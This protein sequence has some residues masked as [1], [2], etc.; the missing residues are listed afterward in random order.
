[1][2]YAIS[3]L[4]TVRIVFHLVEFSAGIDSSTNALFSTEGYTLGLDAVTMLLT[5]LLLALVHPGVVLKGPGS[6]F[7]SKKAK[8]AG[9]KKRR[10]MDKVEI[11]SYIV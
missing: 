5:L 11:V 9:R 1:M 7:P 4:I 10:D 3:V 8:K 6:E 2:L